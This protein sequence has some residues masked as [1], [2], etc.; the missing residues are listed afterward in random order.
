MRWHD[1]SLLDELGFSIYEKKALASICLLGVADAATICREGDVPTSKIYRAMERLAELGVVELQPSRPKLYAARS[2]DEVVDR[3]VAV[4]RSRAD[5]FA[6]ESQRLRELFRQ[7]EG[8][9]RGRQAITDLAI[10]VESHGK[11]HLA[12]LTSAERRVLSYLEKGDL[13]AFDALDAQGF[14]VL[15]RISRHAAERGL[16]HRVVFGFRRQTAATLTD[17]LRRH[18]PELAHVTGVR[19]SGELGHPFHVIDDDTV[20]LSLDHPFVPEGRFASLLVRDAELAQKLASGFEELFARAM[21]DLR[22]IRFHP[23]DT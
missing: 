16:Q 10:G 19:Y 6:D 5:R 17:F 2:A 9:V 13:D 1:L 15:R 8:R 22:E 14:R 23:E 21:R 3:L 7:V 12:R 11:R 4:A 18:G 20:I